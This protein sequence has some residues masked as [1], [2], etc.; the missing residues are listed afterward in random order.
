VQAVS[1][2]PMH[3]IYDEIVEVKSRKAEPHTF[4][5][6]VW[7]ASH[8]P[9]VVLVEPDPSDPKPPQWAACKIM[10]AIFYRFLKGDRRSRYFEDSFSELREVTFTRCTGSDE[11]AVHY[12][13]QPTKASWL[14]LATIVGEIDT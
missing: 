7:M 11:K 4:R 12:R 2:L 9:P 14:T 8:R 6:R 1:S 13:S 3:L 5:V 10:N